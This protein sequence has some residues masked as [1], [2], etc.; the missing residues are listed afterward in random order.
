VFIALLGSECLGSSLVLCGFG[1]GDDISGL[2]LMMYST[3]QHTEVNVQNSCKRQT[4]AV[5][6][7]TRMTIYILH[8]RQIPVD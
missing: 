3:A 1:L 7:F 2:Q 5:N 8:S 4:F 6:K